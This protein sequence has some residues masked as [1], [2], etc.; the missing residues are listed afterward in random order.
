[1]DAGLLPVKGLTSAK[2]RLAPRFDDDQRVEIARALLDD[3]LRLCASVEW[4]DWWVVCDDDEVA[5]KASDR[6]LKVAR[7]ESRGL[8]AALFSATEHLT[9]AGAG[10]VTIVPCDVPLAWRGDLQDLSDT[11]AT[12]DMVIVPSG[13]GGTNGLYLSPPG[14][15]T[16]VFGAG[17]LK[18]HVDLARSLA[19]RC[20][21]LELPRLALDIDTPQDVDVFLARPRADETSVGRLLS[22]LSE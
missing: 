19:I 20:S 9:S 4:L 5:A 17:S 7:D 11:G 16:P 3:A 8:N 15:V 2:R 21:I 6:G 12:S 10:S 13:D 18:A 14:L 1:M 22:R